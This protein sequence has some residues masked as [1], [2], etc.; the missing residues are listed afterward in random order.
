[1]SIN[2]QTERL[3]EWMSTLTLQLT[4]KQILKTSHTRCSHPAARLGGDRGRTHYQKGKDMNIKKAGIIAL[5][6]SSLLV[7]PLVFAQQDDTDSTVQQTQN[8]SRGGPRGFGHHGFGGFFGRDGVGFG[9]GMGFP[10]RG[11]ELGTAATITFYDGDPAAGG[12]VLNTLT[13][14]YGED[15]EVAF[16]RQFEEARANAAYMKVDL[17]EQTRTVDLSQF[18]EAERAE[19]RPRELG[20]MNAMSDGTTITARFYNSDPEAAGATPTETLTFTYGVSSAAGFANDFA[21]AAE[22]AQFVTI[23][24]SPQS[25]TVNLAEVQDFNRRGPRQDGFGPRFNDRDSDQDEPNQNNSDQ[26]N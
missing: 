9:R 13:F 12:A 4:S 11:L 26:T 2:V 21:T 6:A 15:S 10:L 17:S 16:A 5:T 8:D 24:T 20:R 1:M 14:T 23:T 18:S 22:S 19:L 3:L 7:T 25:Y